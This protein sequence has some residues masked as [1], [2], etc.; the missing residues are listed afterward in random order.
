MNTL[1]L[2]V[3]RKSFQIRKTLSVHG[4]IL[5]AFHI[6]NV[7]INAVQRNTSSLI[8]LCDLA[9]V[10]L[11]LI[12]P[13]ALTVTERPERRN[14]ASA[15]DFPELLD[16]VLFI[17]TSDD[18]NYQ[19]ILCRLDLHQIPPSIA[20][21]KFHF[22]GIVEECSKCHITANENEVVRAI[23]RTSILMVV[24]IVIVPAHILPAPLIDTA[25]LFAQT[26][27]NIIFRKG[28][29]KSSLIVSFQKRQ[30]VLCGFHFCDN[31]IGR[32]RCSEYILFDHNGT[33]FQIISWCLYMRTLPLQFF[34]LYDIIR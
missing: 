25:N 7:Q 5:V 2:H 20:D 9:N 15:D 8:L 29:V 10:L 30:L 33:S 24:G 3:F 11:G 4:K 23:K 17:F 27:Y 13:T 16:N 14:I 19:I 1:L 31:S 26:V 28:I 18:I 22:S 21:V 34:L 12:T 6:V 32:E